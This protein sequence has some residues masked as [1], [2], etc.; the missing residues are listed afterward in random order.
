MQRTRSFAFLVLLSLFS[1]TA[2]G[3]NR[4]T[5]PISDWKGHARLGTTAALPASTFSATRNEITV[6]AN[7]VCADVDGVTPA[8][9]DRILVQDEATPSRNGLYFVEVLGSVS[10]QCVLRRSFDADFSTEVVS[11]L[12]VF[13]SEGSAND[14]VTFQITTADP[15]V[16]NTTSLT[17]TAISSGG[18]GGGSG[19]V[20]GPGASTDNAIVRFNGTGGT[21]VQNSAVTIADTSGNISLPALGTVDGRDVSVDGTRLDTF[22]SSSTD[23][24]ICRFDGASGGTQNSEVT[25]GDTGSITLGSGDT[26]D[27]RDPSVDGTRLD[28]F[29]AVSTDNAIVRFD[30]TTGGTQNSV[31]T[32]ADTTGNITL[33]A[34]STIDGRDPSVDGTKLDG[35]EASADANPMTTAGDVVYGGASGVATR[36]AIGTVGKH[37]TAFSSSAPSW[38]WPV[39]TPS[40]V[41]IFEDWI[42]LATVATG[43]GLAG[44][45]TSTSGTGATIVLTAGEANHPGIIRH[46]T[47]TS[48]SGRASYGS[49]VDGISVQTGV[50]FFY[51]TA[52]RVNT[53][54]DGTDRFSVEFGLGDVYQAGGATQDGVFFRYIDNVS[55]GAWVCN[56]C[57]GG[58]CTTSVVGSAVVA[59]TWYRLGLSYD[60]TTL[61]CLVNGASIGT[62][63][64]SDANW[65]TSAELTGLQQRVQGQ[66][67]G[68][69]SR[70]V[71]SDFVF[72]RMTVTR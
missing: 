15:I 30:G 56:I 36:L 64:S 38:Q 3:Q 13:V 54:S 70:T 40:E 18:G 46:T 21:S 72:F 23:N 37:L 60:G 50:G 45:A 51:E 26:I 27:G 65:P 49:S 11:G 44:F 42:T 52:V 59:A 16:L 29:V 55:A 28:S 34:L 61:T 63:L 57:G 32:I 20:V 10:S 6:T 47:G 66:A 17:F 33:P 2:L 67:L 35:I 62:Y 39:N 5:P 43:T 14:G 41:W 1:T 69:N 25:I 8:L 68:T 58:S 22:A 19:D 24:A 12:T 48:G 4:P 31:V 9:G 7:G 71:D 53:L